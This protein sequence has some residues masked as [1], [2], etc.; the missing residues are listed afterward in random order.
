MTNN[1][2]F[3]NIARKGLKIKHET[4][5]QKLNKET[6]EALKT[7]DNPKTISKL[8]KAI[9]ISNRHAL[10]RIAML[11]DRD[12]VEAKMMCNGRHGRYL[13]IEEKE[14]DESKEK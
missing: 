8:A 14:T 5:R 6:L 1:K 12:L 13:E 7:L 9:G 11:K 3:S 10:N 2:Y 4:K